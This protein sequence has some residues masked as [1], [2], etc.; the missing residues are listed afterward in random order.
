MVDAT[1]LRQF[2]L[3]ARSSSISISSV[4]T[5]SLNLSPSL[6]AFLSSSTSKMDRVCQ[7][8][9]SVGVK[10]YLGSLDFIDDQVSLD[11]ISGPNPV[12]MR[13]LKRSTGTCTIEET[14]YLATRITQ[15]CNLFQLHLSCSIIELQ[16]VGTKTYDT[17]RMMHDIYLAL[18]ELKLVFRTHGSLVSLASD[19]LYQSNIELPPLLPPD[20]TAWSFSL[21][22]LFYNVLSVEL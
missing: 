2:I 8:V 22:T 16:F 3:D 4:A 5:P 18:S 12:M 17:H 9:T 1:Q 19:A 15:Y 10:T 6:S 11:S 21:V 20:T 13:V 14:E 7:S